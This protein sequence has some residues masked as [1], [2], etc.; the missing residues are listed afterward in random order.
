[1]YLTDVLDEYVMQQLADYEDLKF[2]NIA[3]EDI[4]H[5]DKV[6]VGGWVMGGGG[7]EGGGRSSIGHCEEVIER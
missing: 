2:V 6:R 4:E 5:L 3:K 1:M 7:S